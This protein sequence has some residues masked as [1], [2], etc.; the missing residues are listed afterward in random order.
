[1]HSQDRRN[2]LKTSLY[3]MVAMIGVSHL[4]G[5]LGSAEALAAPRGEKPAPKKPKEVALPAGQNAVPDGDAIAKAIGYVPDASKVDQKK[6]KQFKAGQNCSN[7]TLYTKSNEGWGKCTMIQSGLVA[8]Q[9]W[10]GSY[11]KK[12]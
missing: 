10:C 4:L 1:M 6:F 11:S 5:A 8:A 12:A 9:G 7:C 2:F 3:S